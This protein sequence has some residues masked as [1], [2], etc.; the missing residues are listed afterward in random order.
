MAVRR[1]RSGSDE[2]IISTQLHVSDVP[3]QLHQLSI[4][5]DLVLRRCESVQGSEQVWRRC[6]NGRD[7]CPGDDSMLDT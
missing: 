1:A 6:G 5:H 2:G 4:G 3:C 7:Q